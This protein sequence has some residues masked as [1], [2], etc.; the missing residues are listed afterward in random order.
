MGTLAHAVAAA[1]A[2]QKLQRLLVLRADRT[3]KPLMVH[4]TPYT[5]L[6]TRRHLDEYAAMEAPEEGMRA[7]VSFLQDAARFVNCRLE[8]QSP[9]IFDWAEAKQENGIIFTTAREESLKNPKLALLGLDH[10]L[11]AGLL[12]RFRELPPEEIALK[13]RSPDHT[14]GSLS[15]WQVETHGGRGEGKTQIVVVG[16]TDDGGRV[17]AWERQVDTIYRAESASLDNISDPF[18]AR[19]KLAVAESYLRQELAQRGV[20]QHD[21][22]YDAKLIGWLELEA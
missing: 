10:P 19:K 2:V 12:H 13:V 21:G 4:P 11:V 1:C 16:V 17:F 18:I 7:I 14:P 6:P 9:T 5:D 15:V 8:S 20:S 22:G 3:D